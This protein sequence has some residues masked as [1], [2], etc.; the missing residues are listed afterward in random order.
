MELTD[1]VAWWGAVVATLVFFWDV[2]KWFNA[3]PR[4]KINIRSYVGYPD[5]RVISTQATET[6]TMQEL[7][8][9]CH[10]EIINTGDRPTTLITIEGAHEQSKRDVKLYSSSACFTGHY[11][12]NLP[13]VL[14]PGE[15]W[16]C[17]LEMNDIHRLA[18]YGQPVIKL[19]TSHKEHPIS[20]YPKFSDEKVKARDSQG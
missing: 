13:L 10:I 12:K 2:A 18:E 9:Y 4:L 15:M 11:G 5:S 20:I 1:F 16:S 8:E 6:G 14:G 3:G 7:A 19:Q 17:R